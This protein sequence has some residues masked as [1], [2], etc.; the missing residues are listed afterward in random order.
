M[1]YLDMNLDPTVFV[2]DDDEAMRRSLCWLI[3]SVPL[4]VESFASA[5]DFLTAYQPF[6]PGCLV[7]DVRM[8]GLSGL[9]L[10]DRLASSQISIPIIF[11]TGHGTVPMAVWAMK[12]GA[13]EFLPKPFS[14]Q[15]LLE[16]IQAALALDARKRHDHQRRSSLAE[17]LIH[18]TP[19]EREVMELVITGKANKVIA[20]QLGVSCKTVEVHRAKIMTKTQADSVID[21]VRM[22]D[23]EK[24]MQPHAVPVAAD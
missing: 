18:L 8:P 5:Q 20:G 19:R 10:Q 15:V 13:I 6:Q 11:I 7:L 22:A 3:Q 23:A 1:E 16:R 2:I 24:S 17:R 14:D 12:A 9:E 21:L 4:P